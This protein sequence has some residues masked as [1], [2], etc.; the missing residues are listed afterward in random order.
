[1]NNNKIFTLRNVPGTGDC[2]FQ[3][4][5]LASLTSMGLGGNH[6]LLRAISRETR[7]MVAQILQVNQEES[8]GGGG[9]YLII[10][11][12]RLVSTQQLLQSA[13]QQENISTSEYLHRLQLEGQQGGLY[14]GGPE[15]TVLSNVLRR[16]ISIYEVDPDATT[17]MTM[18]TMTQKTSSNK[19][20]TRIFLDQQQQ[21][22]EINMSMAGHNKDNNMMI[23]PIVC[24]GVFGDPIFADPCASIPQSVLFSPNLHPPGAYSWHLHILVLQVNSS[25]TGEKH[26]CVLLPQQ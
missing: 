5:I 20:V 21:E 15:L 23:C 10:A 12:N 22:E 24:K 16:P 19:T 9:N 7:A 2:M 8:S 18:T 13:A 1:M 6:A 3:A 26:A 14:G 11:N 25:L 17:T 4:V